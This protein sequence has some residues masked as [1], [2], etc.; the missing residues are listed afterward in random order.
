MALTN[1]RDL[2]EYMMMLRSHGI[3]RAPE[4]FVGGERLSQAPFPPWYYEQQLLGFNFRMT[5]IH[6]ALGTSQLDRLETYVD[7]RNTLAHRYDAAFRNLPLQ[8]PFVS[9]ENRSAFHLY[10]IRL[11]PNRTSKTRDEVFRDMRSGGIG[12][13]VHYQPVHLQPYYRNLGFAKGQFPEAEA[14]GDSA[15]TLPLYPELS[16]QQFAHVVRT[17]EATL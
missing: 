5:D 9:G 3:T 15:I 2:A 11:I 16:E 10:V 6:A 1:D 4:K 17:L 8:T 13:N 12:V 14:F 7:R